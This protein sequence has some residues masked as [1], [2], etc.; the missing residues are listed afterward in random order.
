[1]AS[2]EIQGV[3]THITGL[4]ANG[5][6]IHLVVPHFLVSAFRLRIPTIKAIHWIGS[7]TTDGDIHPDINVVAP[8]SPAA[9]ALASSRNAGGA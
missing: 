9:A 2:G 4:I 1:M 7:A 5:S 6:D 8:H 3:T